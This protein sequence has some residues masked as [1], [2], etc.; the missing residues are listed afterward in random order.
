[1]NWTEIKTPPRGTKIVSLL[2]AMRDNDHDDYFIVGL[3]EWHP[4]K[5]RYLALETLTTLEPDETK[6]EY[7]WLSEEQAL[8]QLIKNESV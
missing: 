4:S 2:I 1:M 7:Y 8:K 5:R 6:G 3:F